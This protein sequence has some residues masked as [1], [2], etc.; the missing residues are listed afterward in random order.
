MAKVNTNIFRISELKWMGMGKFNSQ[1]LYLLPWARKHLEEMEQPSQS[2]E[3]S[4][5]KYLGAISKM[6]DNLGFFPR[7][8]I[9]YHSNQVSAPT[10]DVKEAKAEWLYETYTTYQNSH[11][12]RFPFH[13]RGL[14]CESR[15]SRDT[16]SKRQVWPWSRK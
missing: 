5:M 16:Q 3:Q 9:Q 13:H 4:K 15:K 12:K 10:T 2:A 11:Q 6:M 7:K 8:T 1:L 14:K